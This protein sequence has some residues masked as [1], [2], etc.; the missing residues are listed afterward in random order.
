MRLTIVWKPHSAAFDHHVEIPQQVTHV[1]TMLA[2]F[3]ALK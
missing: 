1:T 2:T 3:K